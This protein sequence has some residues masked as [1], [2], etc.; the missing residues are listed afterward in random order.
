MSSNNAHTL[1]PLT[2]IPPFRENKYL[3]T[4]LDFSV[5]LVTGR[6]CFRLDLI[7]KH[8]A[9]SIKQGWLHFL[10]SSQTYALQI[11]QVVPISAQGGTVLVRSQ[12][13]GE[14]QHPMIDYLLSV[15]LRTFS[16]CIRENNVE[17]S[18][19]IHLLKSVLP[20][21]RNCSLVELPFLPSWRLYTSCL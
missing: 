3:P 10:G 19:L 13:E 9:A 18:S 14:G 7:L 2:R 5:W 21:H 6:P 16:T 8:S 4:V 11:A 17:L 20:T 12:G 1:S 15:A